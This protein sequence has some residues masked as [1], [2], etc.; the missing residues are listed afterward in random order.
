MDIPVQELAVSV[1]AVNFIDHA[2]HNAKDLWFANMYVKTFARTVRLVQRHARNDAF[3]VF[4]RNT[5]AKCASHVWNPANGDVFT[6]LAINNVISRVNDHVATILVVK[7]LN[8]V[9][10]VLDYVENY[11]PFMPHLRQR[12]S[13]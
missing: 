9:I 10:T 6:T 11:A 1:S 5:A 8:A 2:E 4:V 7:N 12:K 3:I 13:H